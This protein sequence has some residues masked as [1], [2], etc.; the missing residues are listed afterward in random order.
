MAIP[1]LIKC[2]IHNC[3]QIN[4]TVKSDSQEK[5]EKNSDSMQW[6]NDFN[7]S[8]AVSFLLVYCWKAR[9]SKPFLDSKEE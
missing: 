1:A 4:V 7:I 9:D 5:E 2:K 8:Q 3:F 6:S